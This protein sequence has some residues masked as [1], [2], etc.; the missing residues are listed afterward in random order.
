MK[1][2]SATEPEREREQANIDIRNTKLDGRINIIRGLVGVV[3]SWGSASEVRGAE[4]PRRCA[5][6]GPGRVAPS[7][8]WAKA[9]ARDVDVK[10]AGAMPC[11]SRA[12]GV[13]AVAVGHIWGAKHEHAQAYLLASGGLGMT[14]ARDAPAT[15]QRCRSASGPQGRRPAAQGRFPT[16]RGRTRRRRSPAAPATPALRRPGGSRRSMR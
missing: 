14:R 10:L 7:R 12:T 9:A 15:P 16:S 5:Q 11:I 6:A 1:H 13:M 8:A 2:Q 3:R 4:P